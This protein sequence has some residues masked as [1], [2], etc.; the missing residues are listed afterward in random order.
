[1]FRKLIKDYGR[2]HDLSSEKADIFIKLDSAHVV[3][4]TNRSTPE[5]LNREDQNLLQKDFTDIFLNQKGFNGEDIP[6]ATIWADLRNGSPVN[7][8]FL[9]RAGNEKCKCICGSFLPQ[10]ASNG[11]LESVQFFGS[12]ITESVM[13]ESVDK[14]ESFR[15]AFF[16]G[17]FQPDGQILLLNE[18]FKNKLGYPDNRLKDLKHQDFI[19]VEE[20]RGQEYPQFWEYLLAGEP[21]T[22]EFRY[23]D[24]EGNEFWLLATYFAIGVDNAQSRKIIVAGMD[25]TGR[26]ANNVDVYG[27]MKAI[28]SAQAIIHFDMDG[29]ILDAN[30]NFLAMTGYN[31][32]EIKGGNYD[33][34]IPDD[35]KNSENTKKFWSK[36][37]DAEF[38]GGNF[39]RSRKDG[40]DIWVQT[41]YYPIMDLKGKP[42][43]M[44]EYASDITSQIKARQ[45]AADSANIMLE[46]VRNVAASVDE[47]DASVN[48]VSG[49]MNKARDLV[50]DIHAKSSTADDTALRLNNAA[51]SMDS[52]VQLIQDIAGQITL[53]SLNATIEAARAGEAGKGFAVVATEV[54]SLATQ[55]EE[56]TNK[57]LEE[58]NDMQDVSRE[59]VSSLTEVNKSI[60]NVKDY[61]D[62]VAEAIEEQNKTISGITDNMQVSFEGVSAITESLNKIVK[63]A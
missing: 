1:M 55:T 24:M 4:R 5:I 48:E 20:I 3:S 11:E 26:K 14:L 36:I 45:E 18:K 50:E 25:V 10:K 17:E 58:I 30:E 34:F 39:K 21:K 41:S 63:E 42:A 9:L 29:T 46:N 60:K 33:L 52:I 32:K 44:A 43:K 22:G 7:G 19:D 12:D 13:S 15:D 53:L 31:L 49:N 35:E 40:K 37:N 61:V 23:L 27:Q 62:T 16:S 2:K 8:H 6:F 57:I 38:I 28:D 59:T 54:K 51:K 56:A 47:L